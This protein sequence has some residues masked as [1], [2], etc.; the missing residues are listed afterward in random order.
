[1][2]GY[3][4]VR[5]DMSSRC[6]DQMYKIGET[7][8]M[9]GEMQLCE[10][11][12]HFCRNILDCYSYYELSPFTIILE[13]DIPDGAKIIT[14]STLNPSN[15][16]LYSV[17]GAPKFCTNKMKIMRRVSQ[18][19][20]IDAIMAN[21]MCCCQTRFQIY[22]KFLKICNQDEAINFDEFELNKSTSLKD[23]FTYY[24]AYKYYNI[25]SCYEY[26]KHGAYSDLFM[27]YMYK[28]YRGIMT[29][30]NMLKIYLGYSYGTRT[31]KND[32]ND[33]EEEKEKKEK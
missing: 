32:E 17:Y 11:G 6:G 3:K 9:D 24:G 4:A 28:K 10:R 26:G 23:L 18:N 15:Y 22:L 2:K 25:I 16:G 19:E 30:E 5:P 1:M 27:E 33:D 7:Y 29:E 8:E 14:E 12:F 21:P 20:I 13:V 31:G